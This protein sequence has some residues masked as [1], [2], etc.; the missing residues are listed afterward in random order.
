MKL[1][2][3]RSLDGVAIEIVLEISAK[4]SFMRPG[5]ERISEV[6]EV[7]FPPLAENSVADQIAAIDVA[8]GEVER[9]FYRELAQLDNRKA[10]LRS[11]EVAA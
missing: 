5:Y 2:K 7:D 6:V 3:Y 10:Q 11:M 4:D 9:K 8:R 1:A